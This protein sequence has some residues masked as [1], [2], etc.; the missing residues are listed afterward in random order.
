[1]RII[2]DQVAGLVGLSLVCVS[3]L[4]GIYIIETNRTERERVS[5][6]ANAEIQEIRK[7]NLRKEQK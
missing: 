2:S 5:A 6:A 4:I 1:M 7:E 3:V